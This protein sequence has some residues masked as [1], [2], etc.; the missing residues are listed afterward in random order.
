MSAE[1]LQGLVE[2]ALA[3]SAA[4]VL[5]LALRLP[6]RRLFGARTAYA[7]WLLLP[8]ALI[9]VLLPSRRAELAMPEASAI[10]AFT[11]GVVD[12]S[13]MAPGT[14]FA[15][16]VMF[17]WAGGALAMGGWLALRQ[18]R[19][20]RELGMLRQHPDGS[21]R[22]ESSRVGPAVIGAWRGRVVLPADFDQ[23][24]TPLQ[25]ELVLCHERAHVARYDLAVNLLAATLRCLH[26]FNPLLHYAASRLRF[27]QELAADALVLAQRPD[28]RRDYADAMLCTQLLSDPPPLG[29]HWQPAHPLKERIMMLKYPLPGALRTAI[30]TVFAIGLSLA[31]GYAAWAA[32]P[33]GP[34][35]SSAALPKDGDP[36]LVI[37]LHK[38]G[39]VWS[40]SHLFLDQKT[41]DV[42][43]TGDGTVF[44]YEVVDRNEQRLSI[45]AVVRRGGQIV[46]QPS[47]TFARGQDAS[48]ALDDV[49]IRFD[50]RYDTVANLRALR[51]KVVEQDV[52]YNRIA[53]PKYPAGALEDRAQ[54][55]AILRVQVDAQGKPRHVAIDTSS[56]D[57][58]LDEAAIATVR[59]WRFNPAQV[60]GVAVEHQ[61]KVPITFRLDATPAGDAAS[62]PGTLDEIYIAARSR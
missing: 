53:P 59:E 7:L 61:V 49:G 62:V 14:G 39:A 27:D 33:G 51:E 23:R 37:I 31:A 28:A 32:Q 46:S 42:V 54:G 21:W 47:I 56:G 16:F 24:Y 3:A 45:H 58:R 38:D 20:L 60:D 25:R 2:T 5:V 6:M 43:Q 57:V 52:T 55:T 11:A 35:E 36:E 10:V 19:F 34:A 22:A 40:Q 44:E 9:A 12:A 30:G 4:A 29:C 50:F 15:P 13:P 41:S 1:L 48:I 18:R 17:A 26:W 8:V